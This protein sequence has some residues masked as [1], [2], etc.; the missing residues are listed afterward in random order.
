MFF[1]EGNMNRKQLTLILML[2]GSLAVVSGCA[3]ALVGAGAGTVAYLKGSLNA[4]LDKDVDHVYAASLKA[5]DRLEIP[6]T[7]KEKDALSAV[8]VGRTSADKKVTI[9]IK[10]AENNLTKLSIK[11][12]FF[13]NQPQ[14]RLI[15]DE[16]KKHL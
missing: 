16:I 11:I 1:K 6:A 12:G 14:S 7:R 9:K 4:V 15:Y 10:A 8:I 2:C 5:L 13:G 3:V